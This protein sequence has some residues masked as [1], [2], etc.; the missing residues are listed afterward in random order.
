MQGL[1]C[2]DGELCV[3]A[4][5][6]HCG[7]ADQTGVCRPRPEVCAEIYAPVCGCDDRT[8]GNECDAHRAGVSV[9]SDG[10]CAAG[11]AAAAG[12]GGA[13]GPADARAAR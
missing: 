12:G 3:Y 7:A 6:A 2:A 13:T 1:A 4:R 5:D 8:Y 11:G 10:E 9:A